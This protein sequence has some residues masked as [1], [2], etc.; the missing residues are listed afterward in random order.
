MS[1]AEIITRGTCFF[2]GGLGIVVGLS[3]VTGV[4]MTHV[5][6]IWKRK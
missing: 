4:N 5:Y 6:N 2:L 1:I 3:M